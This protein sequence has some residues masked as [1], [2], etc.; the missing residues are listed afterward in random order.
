MGPG[1][2]MPSMR[3]RLL[4]L[5]LA[6]LQLS[7]HAAAIA[8]PNPTGPY[9]VGKLRRTIHHTYAHDPLAPNN[10]STAF[11]MTMFYPT[12]QAPTGPPQPYLWDGVAA[13]YE[14]HWNYTAGTQPSSSAP[15]AAAPR[16]TAARSC[17]PTSRRTAT[18]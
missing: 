2:N 1:S 18:S 16:W 9:H 4:Q 10:V 3:F 6:G 15:A 8:L 12:P 5:C 13:Y 7:N 17:S 11:L 14:A